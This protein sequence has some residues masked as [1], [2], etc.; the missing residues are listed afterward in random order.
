MVATGVGQRKGGCGR[1]RERGKSRKKKRKGERRFFFS[2]G[3]LP[4]PRVSS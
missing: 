4:L 2:E 3:G 1:D